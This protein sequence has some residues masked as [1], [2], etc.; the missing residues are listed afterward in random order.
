M[1]KEGKVSEVARIE[2][3]TKLLMIYEYFFFQKQLI[4]LRLWVENS[5]G[6][7]FHNKRFS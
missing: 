4:N 7:L 6:S 2:L 1:K 3:M 5:A